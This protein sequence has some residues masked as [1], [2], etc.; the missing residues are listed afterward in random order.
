MTWT[1]TLP[2]TNETP[3]KG[4][5]YWKLMKLSFSGPMLVLGSVNKKRS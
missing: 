1:G 3:G 4:D 5:S 2:E